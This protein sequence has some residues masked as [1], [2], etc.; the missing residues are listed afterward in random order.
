MSRRDADRARPRA[1]AAV[2][3]SPAAVPPVLAP[4]ERPFWSVMIPTWQPHPAYLEAAIRSVL[5]QIDHHEKPQIELVDDCSSDFDPEAFVGR[6]DPGVVSVRRHRRHLGL[7]G[8]WN[9]CLRG[10]RGRWVHILH[11]D[12]FVL[13]GFYEALRRGIDHDPRVG[14]AFCSS[15]LDDATGRGW[16]PRLVPMMTAG[17]LDDW[18]RHVFVRL[19]IQCSAIV[20]RRDVYEALGGFDPAFTYAVD[21]DMWKRI[22]ARYPI[23]YHPQPLACYRMHPGSETQRQRADGSHLAEVF[24]SIDRSAA[25]LPPAVAA[26]VVRCARFHYAVFAVENALAMIHS[27][28]TWGAARRQLRVARQGSSA[29]A[30]IA[31]LIRVA[32][33]G[34][35]RALAPARGRSY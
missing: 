10:A 32:V 26:R 27:K 20:V 13:P 18:L 17:I 34:G 30:I 2:A 28:G 8:N 5:V 21:W 11:Q 14:A 7:A 23:W 9:A 6:F 3:A 31:A 16:A 22:A 4:L 12:D 25:L 1:A 24:R 33:R 29:L 15:Y 19:S 35:M